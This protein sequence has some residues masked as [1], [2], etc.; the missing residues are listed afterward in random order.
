[1]L[2]NKLRLNK[3]VSFRI[4][5]PNDYN[6]STIDKLNLAGIMLIDKSS[7]RS[8]ELHYRYDYMDISNYTS[9]SFESEHT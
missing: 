9:I 1:M 8:L 5:E 6:I 3:L 2:F 7:V 4:F